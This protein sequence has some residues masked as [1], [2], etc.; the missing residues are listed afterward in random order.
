L[1]DGVRIE[2]LEASLP[3]VRR[4]LLRG[5]FVKDAASAVEGLVGEREG[6]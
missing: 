4:G 1:Q 6:V 2:R 3:S 5:V